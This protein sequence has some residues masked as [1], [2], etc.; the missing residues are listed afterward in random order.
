[1]EIIV[2]QSD[3]GSREFG[4]YENQQW[5]K[6]EAKP[7]L[8]SPY[9]ICECVCWYVDRFS[10]IIAQEFNVHLMMIMSLRR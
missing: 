5:C 4:K 6:P 8:S 3:D 10:F 1:M 7:L 9:A 2:T